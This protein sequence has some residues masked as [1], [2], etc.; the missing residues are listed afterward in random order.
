MTV[1]VDANDRFAIAETIA[2]YNRS[3]DNGDRAEFLS[4]FAPDGIKESQTYWGVLSGHEALGQW[5]DRF[6][7]DGPDAATFRRYQGGQ[8]RVENLII[9]S[10]ERD[11]VHTW[12][13][14]ILV[15][16][17]HDGPKVTV[18]GNYHDIFVRRDGRWLIGKRRIEIVS[19]GTAGAGPLA[20]AKS[21][22]GRLG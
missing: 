18:I 22:A 10:A 12:S 2:R 21:A 19:D 6:F 13:N 7:G 15:I 14:F 3:I 5:F 8:H 4:V 1:Q 9:E 11:E 17:F 20:P 16:P